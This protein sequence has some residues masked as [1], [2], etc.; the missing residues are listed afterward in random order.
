MSI[1]YATCG[2]LASV[3]APYSN[4]VTAP[5]T[6]PIINNAEPLLV[7]F[8]KPSNESGQMAGHNNAL[9]RPSKAI[10]HTDTDPFTN[11]V[12]TVNTIPKMADVINA[13]RWEMILGIVNMPI[14]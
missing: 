6:T 5:P 1:Q 14:Q 10:N 11:T 2:L 12:K 9:P 13:F 4:G 3:M 7:A 8:P